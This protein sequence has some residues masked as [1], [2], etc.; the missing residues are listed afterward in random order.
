MKKYFLF[1]ISLFIPFSCFAGYK[2]ELAICG[3]FR[4]DAAYL[5][6]WIEFHQLMGVEYFYLCSHNG[7]DH[8][9]NVLTPYIDAGIVELSIIETGSDADNIQN[10]NQIQCSYYNEC[11][12]KARKIC[13]WV[14]FL[15]T[16]EFLYPTED[17][18]LQSILT[19]FSDCA[20]IAVDWHMFG[21]SG[22]KEIPKNKLLIECLTCCLPLEQHSIHHVK[23]I[24]QPKYALEFK[25][26]HHAEYQQGYSQVNTDRVPF[27]GPFSPYIQFKELK[28][29]HYW[30]RDENYYYHYKLPRREK[31]GIPREAL[32]KAIDAYNVESNSD[33]LRFVPQLRK[34]MGYR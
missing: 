13:K 8:Y 7:T 34:K 28:I 2:Y 30:M 3:I 27:S 29:N 16:D 15:D 11:L 20:G 31:W 32:I 1:I 6:E 25:C 33:I 18:S 22:V 21:T 17:K 23:S 5:K 14:A 19:K 9:L 26:P 24:V 4:D 12:K 10:F